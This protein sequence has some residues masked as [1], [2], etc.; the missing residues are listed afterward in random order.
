MMSFYLRSYPTLSIRSPIGSE[1]VISLGKECSLPSKLLSSLSQAS[2]LS[3][4]FLVFGLLLLGPLCYFLMLVLQIFNCTFILLTTSMCTGT[5][6]H[7]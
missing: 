3:F 5:S 2:P 1:A 4:H 7:F 6:E